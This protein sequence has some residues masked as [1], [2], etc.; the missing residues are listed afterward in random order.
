[1]RISEN[2]WFLGEIP[3]IHAFEKRL[4]IGEHFVPDGRRSGGNAGLEKE[5]KNGE[6]ASVGKN[7]KYGENA[8]YGQRIEDSESALTGRDAA[9]KEVRAGNEEKSGVWEADFCLE[10]SA[11]V[12]KNGKRLFVITGCSHSGICNIVSYAERVFEGCSVRGILGGFHLFETDER[13]RKTVEFLREKELEE[14][15]PC[16][17]VSLTVKCEMSRVMPVKEVGVGMCLEM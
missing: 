8:G 7:A 11:L 17:C 16:H 6:G 4:A 10:D 1:M 15:M 14:L 2:I 3:K 9:F 13:T 5:M 12:Y